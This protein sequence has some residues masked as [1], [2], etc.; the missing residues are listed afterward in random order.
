MDENA[1]RMVDSIMEIVNASE[2]YSFE[3]N[4]APIF[5]ILLKKWE[6]MLNFQ[7][8]D[9][10]NG[11]LNRWEKL[12]SS[13]STI[14]DTNM[15]SEIEKIV[16]D[17]VNQKE[18][19]IL[20]SLINLSCRLDRSDYIE[21]ID[22]VLQVVG[23][24]RLWMPFEDCEENS[25]VENLTS[26]IKMLIDQYF[27]YSGKCADELPVSVKKVWDSI[28][29]SS[30]HKTSD[31]TSLF[32]DILAMFKSDDGLLLLDAALFF[33]NKY[34]S[35]YNECAR[36]NR[37]STTP[38]QLEE[39]IYD[40]KL[41]YVATKLWG[42]ISTAYPYSFKKEPL[43][44]F[45]LLVDCYVSN[46][47]FETEIPAK[48][49]STLNELRQVTQ[50]CIDN[51]AKSLFKSFK[52]TLSLVNQDE[53]LLAKVVDFF[54]DKYAELHIDEGGEYILPETLINFI[55]W[56]AVGCDGCTTE[57][58]LYNPFAGLASYG[59]IHTEML[60]YQLNSDI[61]KDKDDLEEVESHLETYKEHSWYYGVESNQ[62]NRLIGSVRLLVSNPTNLEQMYI[63][64]KDSLVDEIAGLTGGWT[65]IA[66]PPIASTEMSEEK[67]VS[68][69]TKLFD[70]FIDAEGMSD[71]YFV[72]PK[73]FCYDSAYAHLRNKVVSKCILR[74]VIDLPKEIFK[75]SFEAIVVHLN[76]LK[77][78]YGVNHQTLFVDA[79][80][81]QT[82]SEIED[83]RDIYVDGER[84]AYCTEVDPLAISQYYY[85]LIP[86]LYI[87]KPI[88]KGSGEMSIRLGELITLVEGSA[89]EEREGLFIIDDWFRNDTKILFEN[90]SFEKQMVE[91]DDARLEGEHIILTFMRNKFL[92]CKT[93]KDSS[94][95]LRRNQVAF[96][97]NNPAAFSLDY[98]IS[99]ILRNGI[100]DRASL[101]MN[102]VDFSSCYQRKDI[103][104]NI[105]RTE[106]LISF[107]KSNQEG[108]I[109]ALRER[110]EQEILAEEEA[111]KKRFAHREAS[112]DISH[113]LGTT[114][115]RIGDCITELKDI[116]EALPVV[117]QMKDCFDYMKRFID[118][119]GQ[120]FSD[121][122]NKRLRTEKK[123]VNDFI[124]KYCV[125]WKNYGKNTFDVQY[126]SSVDD[127]TTFM[128]HDDFMKVL[129]D[130][131]LDNVYRHGFDRFKSPNHKVRISTSY[132]SMD[133][134]K[135]VLLSVANNGKPFPKDFSIEKYISRG[136][137]CGESGRTGLGG[138]HI[139]NITKAHKGFI[140]L[141]NDGEW[142]VIVEILLP[143]AYYNDC[144]TDKFMTY[145][146][147]KEC[148]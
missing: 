60:R 63:A 139:Y 111:E 84:T 130:T 87:P 110:Y 90:I 18:M 56:T 125:G 19:T 48:W 40:L 7:H 106:I 11:L 116:E 59:K 9:L 134:K 77:Y 3:E 10:P 86:E 85:C 8:K 68:V 114:F 78:N 88:K 105:M 93:S 21:G 99:S 33:I 117:M 53:I 133:E 137:F 72:L 52:E 113:M 95:Y 28:C 13:E 144:C 120:N 20:N 22:F 107:D 142:N 12:T 23:I 89:S 92:I 37:P 62:T 24:Q 97:V 49:K 81:L 112:S 44:V 136:E 82:A 148:L 91:K 39:F 115:D 74:G 102:G 46:H 15:L 138:N 147:A 98:L 145:G 47:T 131:L 126:E 25:F 30:E 80:T 32:E 124:N 121:L 76:K 27:E 67:F 31:F 50:S 16:N 4:P 54:V 103:I 34:E 71:A 41:D 94:F 132:V 2:T 73:S 75:T 26:M 79:R 58:A 108:T 104:D 43:P 123:R 122:K 55:Y 61:K 70:K 101:A 96:K 42:I 65:F 1:K 6:Q 57:L 143:V 100:L 128:I 17:N 51:T 66:T 146:H 38:W 141:T 36:N 64:A 118:S 109:S 45:Q 69:L 29:E 83:L 119:V 129:L 5:N 135:F 140:N 35:S 14:F 127:D